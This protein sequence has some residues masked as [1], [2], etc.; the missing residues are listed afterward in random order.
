MN[1]LYLTH[2]IRQMTQQETHK[3]DQTI[4]IYWENTVILLV[5]KE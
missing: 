3:K 2:G 4:K 1:V 5:W